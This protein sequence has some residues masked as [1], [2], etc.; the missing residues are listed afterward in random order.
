MPRNVTNPTSR[1][2]NGSF[3]SI[4]KN[5]IPHANVQPRRFLTDDHT[6]TFPQGLKVKRTH[7]VY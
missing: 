3:S 7:K 5:R 6:L 4:L 2:V 1:K